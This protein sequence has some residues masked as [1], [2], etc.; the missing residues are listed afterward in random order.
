MLNL[1]PLITIINFFKVEKLCHQSLSVLI[2]KAFEQSFAQSSIP[3]GKH[4]L[5]WHFLSY[6][7][8]IFF[9]LQGPHIAYSVMYVFRQECDS[10]SFNVCQGSTLVALRTQILLVSLDISSVKSFSTLAHC[11][12]SWFKRSRR[13]IKLQF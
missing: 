12:S 1:S 2:N 13:G 8:C 11:N 6:L 5:P 9:L 4:L 7:N 3:E 10:S